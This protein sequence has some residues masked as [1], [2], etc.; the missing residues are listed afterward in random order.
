M[1]QN[2]VLISEMDI[3]FVFG[4]VKNSLVILFTLC[5]TI[6]VMWVWRIWYRIN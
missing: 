2:C 3:D 4:V 5:R 6:L 1:S